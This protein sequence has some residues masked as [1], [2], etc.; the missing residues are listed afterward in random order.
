MEV[1]EGEKGDEEDGA[2]GLAKDLDNDGQNGENLI[3]MM[4]NIGHSAQ[5]HICSN[6]MAI[7]P[8]RGDGHSCQAASCTDSSTLNG[9]FF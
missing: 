7:V 8:G 6:Q 5:T 9:N 1:D 3:K 2:K 4:A